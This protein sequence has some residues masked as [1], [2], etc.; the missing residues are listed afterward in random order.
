MNQTWK[1]QP[2]QSRASGC[3]PPR[4]APRH[5]MAASP[6]SDATKPACPQSLTG[7]LLKERGLAGIRA[8]GDPGRGGSCRVRP[9]V[10]LCVAAPAP[11]APIPFLPCRE[12][13]SC[14]LLTVAGTV[15]SFPRSLWHSLPPSPPP[16]SPAGTCSSAWGLVPSPVQVGSPG[17]CTPLVCQERLPSASPWVGE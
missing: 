14:F 9:R 11:P 6:A 8:G 16:A 5:G 4:M 15:G 17:A 10:L 13:E 7:P 2:S 3:E 1:R 12:G